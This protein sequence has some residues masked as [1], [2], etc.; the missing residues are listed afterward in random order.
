M[1]VAGGAHKSDEECEWDNGLGQSVSLEQS[2]LSARKGSENTCVCG[3]NPCQVRWN[4]AKY[5]LTGPPVHTQA[6]TRMGPA[7]APLHSLKAAAPASPKDVAED[8]AVAESATAE[9]AA[10]AAAAPA[11]DEQLAAQEKVHAALLSLVR[12]LRRPRAYVGYT[13]FILFALCKKCQPC[14]WEGSNYVDLLDVF[15]PWAVSDNLQPCVM[16]AIPCALIG[17]E[18]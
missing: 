16:S 7:S 2:E 9:V 6:I 11:E 1:G 18:A 5:G 8:T 4:D 10:V 17:R 13:A 3:H 15:A 12:D 14:A